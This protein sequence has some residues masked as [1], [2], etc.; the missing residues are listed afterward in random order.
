[1][2]SGARSF[3]QKQPV[4]LQ[5]CG[6]SQHISHAYTLLELHSANICIRRR[7]N[8][9]RRFPNLQDVVIRSRGDMP[10][11]QRAPRQVANSGGVSPMDEEQFGRSILGIIRRLLFSD[12]SEVPNVHAAVCAGR[13]EVDRGVRGPGDLEDVVGV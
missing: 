4:W 5:R 2:Q 6:L 12:R 7:A 3:V 11:G 9:P 8:M 1:M 10:F 13:G